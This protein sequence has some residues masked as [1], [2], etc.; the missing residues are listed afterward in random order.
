M[1]DPPHWLTLET[2]ALAQTVNV[3]T[4]DL[5]EA[6]TAYAERRTPDFKGR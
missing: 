2:E 1:R 4:E 5:G 6:L 3:H